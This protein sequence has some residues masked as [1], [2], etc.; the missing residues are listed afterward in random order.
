MKVEFHGAD[1]HGG[2]LYVGTGCFHMRD[3]LCGMK[4]S[5]QHRH[6]WTSEND[7]IIEE[8]LQ[9]LEERSKALASCTYEENTLWG[10]EVPLSLTHTHI[11]THYYI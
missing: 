11:H 2:P 5:D 7:Q 9:E 8:S 3:T 10:K 4:F 6:D 1:G